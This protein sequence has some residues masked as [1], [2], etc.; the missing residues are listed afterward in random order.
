[1]TF[2]VRVRLLCETPFYGP[3]VSELM[4]LIERCGSVAGACEEM[5]MSYSKGRG[6]I[7]KMEKMLDF[8]IVERVQGGRGGGSAK[9]TPRGK[10]LLEA[11]LAYDQDIKAYAKER[12][13]EAF[14]SFTQ[15]TNEEGCV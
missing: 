2:D 14:C 5:G 13:D 15:N 3:G 7:R 6:I 4:D 12:F 8:P 9:L 11:Y 10:E 1:M